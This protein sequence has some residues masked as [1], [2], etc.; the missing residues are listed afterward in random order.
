MPT[1]DAIV[2]LPGIMGSELATADG[3]VLWGFSNVKDAVQNIVTLLRGRVDELLVT[4]EDR[5]SK[6]RVKAT[7]L[8][9]YPAFLERWGGYEE[10]S[11]LLRELQDHV[12]DHRAIFAFPYDWRLSIA[13]NAALLARRSDEHLSTWREIVRAEFPAA[14][15]RG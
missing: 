11:S 5:S 10:Y 8:L 9:S 4:D 13:H 15:S 12:L 3:R 14:P 1:V 6:G 7:K 2:V